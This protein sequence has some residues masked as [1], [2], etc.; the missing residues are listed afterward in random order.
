MRRFT[1]LSAAVLAA[2]LLSPASALADDAPAAP[3]DQDVTWLAVQDEFAV[4]LPDGTTYDEDSPPPAGED[5]TMSLPVGA[6]FFLGEKLYATDDKTTRGDQVGRTHV[7]CTAQALP[8]WVL[9]DIVFALDDDSQLHGTVLVEFSAEQSGEP[10][11]FDIAVTGGTGEFA[12][13]NGVVSLTDTTDMS[14]PAAESTTLYEVD[15]S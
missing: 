3:D 8:D 15:L 11:A 14:D 12:G 6:Q 1:V 5:P 10:L 13:A 9:C 7:E 2:G 4:V